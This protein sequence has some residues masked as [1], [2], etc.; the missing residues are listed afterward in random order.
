MVKREC[1]QNTQI[2]TDRLCTRNSN[3]D[4]MDIFIPM[5]T[6]Q[7]PTLDWITAGMELMLDSAQQPRDCSI[8]W[9]W[10]EGK[11]LYDLSD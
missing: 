6:A 3:G 5:L 9:G 1:L 4:S 10:S 11:S 7:R 8:F 2:L